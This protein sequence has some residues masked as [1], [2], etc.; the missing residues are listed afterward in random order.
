V[1]AG[2]RGAMEVAQ[3]RASAT[4]REKAGARL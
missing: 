4:C 1:S 3:A 2:S